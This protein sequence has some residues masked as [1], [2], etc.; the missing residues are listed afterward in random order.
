MSAS[1]ITMMVSGMII[2][3]GGFLASV[4]NAVS[5]SRQAK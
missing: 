4:A 5:K 2:L 3:W 1:A